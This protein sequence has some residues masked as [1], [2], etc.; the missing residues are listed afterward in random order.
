ML[1]LLGVTAAVLVAAAPWGLPAAAGE[2]RLKPPQNVEVDMIDDTY[3]LRWDRSREPAGA[4][5]VSADYQISGLVDI[6]TK[7]PGCQH[8]T[9]ATC[10]FS[11]LNRHVYEEIRLR[12]RAEDGGRTSPWRELEPFVPFYGARIGPPKVHLDPEDKAIAVSISPPG[13]THG[14]WHLEHGNFVYNV[15]VWSNATGAQTWNQ[16]IHSSYPRVKVHGLVPETTYCVTAQARLRLHRNPAAFSPVRC[17][18]TTAESE[19]PAPENVKVVVENQTY[20]LRWDYT[21]DNVTFQAQWLNSYLK[22]DPG[23]HPEKWAHVQG[24]ERTPEARCAL[25]PALLHRKEVYFRVR[26][27]RGGSS[28]P[29]SQEREFEAGWQAAVPPPVVALKAVSSHT[30]HVTIGLPG[31]TELQGLL[32]YEVRVWENTSNTERMIVERKTDFPVAGLRPRTLYCAAA[33][34]LR[35]AGPQSPRSGPSNTAC[36]RTKAGGGPGAWLGVGLGVLLVLCAMAAAGKLAH[37]VLFPAG[38]PPSTIGEGFPTEPLENLLLPASVEWTEQC[39]VIEHANAGS[40]DGDHKTY[41][42]QTSQDSG[43]YSIEDGSGGSGGSGSS[44][45]GGGG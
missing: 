24:C 40:T 10:D 26:A 35:G 43:N 39:F 6:W 31:H 45:S 5:A 12:V 13:A 32:T 11:P 7:L 37:Y 42:S 25:P 27:S 22:R 16:T 34:A 8:V 28:S 2:A 29:W 19:L 30:L 20:V 41:A 15:V 1:A 14:T 36:A 38:T 3:T 23:H 17:V 21:W 44:G 33:W 4:V 18:S 9:S